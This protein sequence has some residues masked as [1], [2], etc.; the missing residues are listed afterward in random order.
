MSAPAAASGRVL[1]LEAGEDAGPTMLLLAPESTVTV[2]S[3]SSVCTVP[4]S[5]DGLT[6]GTLLCCCC[7]DGFVV[8]SGEGDFGISTERMA[9]GAEMEVNSMA[10]G[11]DAGVMLVSTASDTAVVDG[12]ARLVQVATVSAGVKVDCDDRAGAGGGGS[13]LSIA[14]EGIGATSDV[15]VAGVGVTGVRGGFDC[16]LC[17]SD[18]R[19]SASRRLYSARESLTLGSSF[20]TWATGVG[21]A[22]DAWPDVMAS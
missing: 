16:A 13:L 12:G 11:A 8:G 22:A 19:R 15:S 20:L 21:V 14:G 1:V 6:S 3:V 7:A 17:C 5:F 4:S 10:R 18:T 9:V 2:V